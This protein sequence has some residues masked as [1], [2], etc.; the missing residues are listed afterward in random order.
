[1]E[2]KLSKEWNVPLILVVAGGGP[3]TWNTILE[4]MKNEVPIVILRRTGGVAD[5]VA[6]LVKPV[7][8]QKKALLILFEVYWFVLEIRSYQI[9]KTRKKNLKRDQTHQKQKRKNLLTNFKRFINHTQS[10]YEDI[11]Y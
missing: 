9:N 10:N 8:V 6:E 7:Y 5:E 4:N 3:G 1:M 2:S 11:I